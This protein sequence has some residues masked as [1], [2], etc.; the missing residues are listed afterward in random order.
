M[1]LKRVA[2]SLAP[3][4]VVDRKSVELLS[5]EEPSL[6]RLIG[7]IRARLPE[8]EAVVREVSAKWAEEEAVVTEG[9]A[10]HWEEWAPG[11]DVLA[12]LWRAFGLAFEKGRDGPQIAA[13]RDG[14]NELRVVLE[15]FLADGLG[16]PPRPTA[17][18]Q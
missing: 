16:R 11:A 5:E 13:L 18:S 9:W 6:N 3:V 4:R 14:P 10:D 7:M 1:V 8:P 2:Q 12:L 17:P 15:G